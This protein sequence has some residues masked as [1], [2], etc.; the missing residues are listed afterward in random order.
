ML[1]AQTFAIAIILGVL[2]HGYIGITI[3]AQPVLSVV[4]IYE[5]SYKF[6]VRLAT[7]I[8]R[9][10]LQGT[11]D[12]VIVQRIVQN[13]ITYKIILTIFNIKFNEY[14]GESS[15]PKYCKCTLIWCIR[16]VSG[17]Q[18]T[19]LVVPFCDSFWKVVVQSLPFGDTLHT[20]IL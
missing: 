20:P 19:T 4:Y 6:I 9:T 7:N 3:Y 10:S 8:P 13:G 5:I 17:L 14:S 18:S 1:T 12:F 2:K 15:L 16:P 11:E